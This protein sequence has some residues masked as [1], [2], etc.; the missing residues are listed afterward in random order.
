MIWRASLSPNIKL[1]NYVKDHNALSIN[2]CTEKKH[3][4]QQIQ[5][6]NTQILENIWTIQL[7]MKFWSNLDALLAPVTPVMLVP[8]KNILH[9]DLTDKDSNSQPPLMGIKPVH[10]YFHHVYKNKDTLILAYPST[11]AGCQSRLGFTPFSCTALPTYNCRLQVSTWLHI[12]FFTCC[13]Y[14]FPG[15]SSCSC[16]TNCLEQEE[17]CLLMASL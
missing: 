7:F 11:I 5:N 12:L 13:A 14:T 16:F 17:K 9:L 1:K 2:R 15:S 3:Y 6:K 8:Y 4:K 10:R